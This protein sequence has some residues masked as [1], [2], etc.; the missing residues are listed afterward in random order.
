MNTTLTWDDIEGVPDDLVYS[1]DISGFVSE[2]KATTI[3]QNAISTATIRADQI[4]AVNIT[5][6]SSD[7]AKISVSYGTNESWLSP[8]AFNVGSDDQWVGGHHGILEATHGVRV[9]GVFASLEGHTHSEYYSSGDTIRANYLYIANLGSAS[10]QALYCSTN[11]GIVGT[12]S[13]SMRYKNSIADV[14]DKMLDPKRL[15]NLPVRQFK[16]N[17]GHFDEAEEYNYNTLNIGFIA[18]EMAEFYPYAVVVS[19]GQVESW[20][21]RRILPAMLALIQDQKKMIDNLSEKIERL[22][23]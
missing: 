4:Y 18:E 10:Q 8:S 16:W 20:E 21:V 15:Y 13:S 11:S 6:S 17:E 22:E 19:K 14:T 23:S 12:D 5:A 9:A 7:D 1:A 2:S 3:A